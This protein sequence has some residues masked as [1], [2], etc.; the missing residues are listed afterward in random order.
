MR[1]PSLPLRRWNE[2]SRSSV[3][4]YRPTGIVMSPKLMAP[5]QMARSEVV[6]R[7]SP[8]SEFL[9]W[10][11]RAS[12]TSSTRSAP[13][14]TGGLGAATTTDDHSWLRH[15]GIHHVI[16]AAGVAFLTVFLAE[17]GDKSQ[18]LALSLSARYRRPVLLAAVL[19]AS[20][21]TIGAAVLVGDLVG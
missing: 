2:M 4:L 18:L 7:S 12:S 1:E 3:A 21:A 20:A 14:I 16:R 10:A 15:E 11:I 6:G 17:L 8:S 5:R 9:V 19:T 13:G